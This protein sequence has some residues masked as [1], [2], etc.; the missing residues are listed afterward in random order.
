MY[1]IYRYFLFFLCFISLHAAEV[2]LPTHSIYFTGQK[3]FD[4]A[5]LEDALGV[6]NKSF[7]AFWK[8]DNPRIK[9]NLLATL[10]ES[11]KSFYK[12][13]GFYD[14]EDDIKETNT[15]VQVTITENEPVRV[16]SIEIQSDYNI[17]SFIQMKKNDIFRAKIFISSKNKIIDA[18]LRQGYC[19]YDLNTKAYVDLDKHQVDL[20]YI[21]KKGDICTF[22]K[23]SVT[24]LK[25]IDN[26]VIVS[27]LRAVEGEKF[28]IEKVQE[29]SNNLYKL[30]SFDSVMIDVN[31]K[32]YNVIPVDIE[33]KE[34][35]K[36]Y[37]MEVGVGYDTYVGPRVHG[38]ITKYNFL[39]N[40]QKL[41]FKASWSKLEQLAV[42]SYYKPAFLNLFGYNLDFGSRIGYSNLEFDGFKEEKS[43]SGAYFIHE[44]GRLSLKIGMTLE[45]INIKALD[46]LLKGQELKQAVNEGNFILSYPYIDFVYDARDSKLNPKN[47]YYL[48][49]HSELGL[50]YDE[51]ASLYYKTQIEAR[52]IHTFSDLTLAMVVKAGVLECESKKGLPE[53][54]YLFLGGAYTNRAYGF[55]EIG[56]ISSPT[57]D[58]IYGASS[59]ANLSLEADY[60]LW[61]K[62]YGAL[63]N[64]NTMLTDTAYNFKGEIISSAG[65][66]VRYM[67]PIG[68]FKLDVGFNIH[69]PSIYGISFQIGQSF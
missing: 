49:A 38:E 41:N 51:S 47:G 3:Y 25:T 12:S 13:E 32:F 69:N 39:G 37:H 58:S 29:T 68:P 40:A 5:T 6:E 30:G 14:I 65:V 64:D 17:S 15:T 28:N 63:F 50:S 55:R 7:F 45:S 42:L 43:F 19:S 60:P 57:K 35:E 53:S 1:I 11:I 52:V 48:A 54:K 67:T 36:P 26:N 31:R 18:L 34:I 21:L 16:K 61:G 59:M 44:N 20:R 24:G 33:F 22:G 27:R 62:L 56:I 46:N 2:T 9:N 66:G 8:S 4:R 10:D 23:L